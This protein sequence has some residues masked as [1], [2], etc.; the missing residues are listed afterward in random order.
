[1]RY[2][3]DFNFRFLDSI[4]I[5]WVRRVLIYRFGLVSSFRV[6]E[7][8]VVVFFFVFGFR[9]FFWLFGSFVC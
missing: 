3:W 1:M 2:S 6:L 5:V 7:R 8:F 4:K 9:N